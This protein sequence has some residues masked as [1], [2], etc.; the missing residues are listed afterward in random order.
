[1]IRIENVTKQY[2]A[3]I[4]FVDA[5]FQLNAGEKVGLVG[6]NGA[7]KTTIF[8][9][10]TGEEQPDEGVVERPRRAAAHLREPR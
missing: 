6:P 4:L 2:G 5:C 10:I 9:L 7:G 8:R 1:M 3:Q